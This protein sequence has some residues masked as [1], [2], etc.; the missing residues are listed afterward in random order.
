[1]DDALGAMVP[2][3][4]KGRVYR[5]RRRVRL[6]DAA[7]S[8]RLRLD[9]CARYLQDVGN[10]DTEDSGLDAATGPSG[11]VWVVR[12]SVVDVLRPPRWGEWL[13][14]ATWCSGTGGRWAGRRLAMVGERG[15]HVEVDTLWVHLRPDT[16]TP[17]RLP[18]A[19]LDI[20]GEAAGG[21]RIAA[22]HVLPAPPAEGPGRERLERVAWPLRV[23]DYD[24]MNH[25]NNA[26]YWSAVEE[27]LACGAGDG[28]ADLRPRDGRPVRAVMEYGAGIPVG[29]DVELLVDR[30]DDR[31]DVW[32]TVDGAVLATARVARLHVGTGD[33]GVLG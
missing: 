23:V 19:F 25:V 20:Y 9:A 29:A 6:G 33:P 15:G 24:V 30:G 4:E 17:A 27:V 2:L 16:L 31:V 11:G 22:R 7:R 5:S 32:F 10:D 3:P 12:R 18:E 28:A 8:Q 26:A 13:D 14:L 1:M 21:R